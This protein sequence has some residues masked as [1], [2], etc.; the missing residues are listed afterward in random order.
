MPLVS[1]RPMLRAAR[2]EGYAV[3]AFNPVDYAS[4]KAI[5]RAAEELDAPVIV[6]TSVKTVKYYG[7]EAI[8]NWMQELAGPSPVPIALHLDHGQDLDVVKECMQAGWTSVMVDASAKPYA[9]NLELST[10][11]VRLAAPMGIGVEAE[12]GKIGGVEEDVVVSDREALLVDVDEA[13]EFCAQLDL[14]V[15]APAIGT[16]HGVYKGEPRIAFDRLEALYRS[17]ETPF[18]LHGGT[19]LSDAIIQ[20]CIAL[21]CAKVN[22]STELK[23]TFLDAFVAYREAHREDHEPLKVLS[24]QF[25]AMKSMIAGKIRQFGGA[26]KGRALAEAYP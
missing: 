16:A 10:E 18:A 5:V 8:V 3:G 15:F 24:A 4:T 12:L 11:V 7:Y 1:M 2:D 26:G 25:E 14:A 17:I 6:Q 23:H 20:R 21:G 22:I 19:G 13:K 9:V